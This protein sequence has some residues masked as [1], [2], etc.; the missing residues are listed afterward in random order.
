M[1]S[2]LPSPHSAENTVSLRGTR[3]L[4]LLPSVL[5]LQR[6]RTPFG[7]ALFLG[8][9]PQ[10]ILFEPFGLLVHSHAQDPLAPPAAIR[11]GKSACQNATQS[12]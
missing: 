9:C 5:R 12:A 4:P 8:R 1:D 7:D 11:P 3:Q 6:E 10:A 2:V